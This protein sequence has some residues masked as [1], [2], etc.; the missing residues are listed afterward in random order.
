MF[1]T[2]NFLTFEGGKRYIV[3]ALCKV[4][5]D[6]FGLL[7]VRIILKCIREDD[8]LQPTVVD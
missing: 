8:Y 4:H 6:W 2:D 1:V 3:K 7:F 5:E